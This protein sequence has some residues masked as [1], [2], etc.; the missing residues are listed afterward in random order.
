M[1][2]RFRARLGAAAVVGGL[3]LQLTGCGVVGPTI[4]PDGA[5]KSVTDMVSQQT[6]FKP[7]DVKCPSGVEAK[8]GQEFDCHFTGPEGPYTAHVKVT[9]VN[10]DDVE[11][12]IQTKRS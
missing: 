11:F 1:T 9:N 4:K 5:A 7:T 12:Y 2:Q 10:G 3:A 6:G 8:V